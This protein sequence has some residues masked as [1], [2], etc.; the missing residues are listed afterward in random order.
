MF[1]TRNTKQICGL[2]SS[3]NTSM[4]SPISQ[5]GFPTFFFQSMKVRPAFRCLHDDLAIEN[6]RVVRQWLK[7][8]SEKPDAIDAMPEGGKM[9]IETGNVYLDEA[10][11][12]K[13]RKS[14]P[15]SS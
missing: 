15:D 9:T 10:Y 14:S 5:S 11:W 8:G 1:L 3:S 13:I 12:R 4:L 6:G 7:R 2:P